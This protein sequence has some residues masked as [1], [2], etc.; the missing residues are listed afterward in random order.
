LGADPA[1]EEIAHIVHEA[2][3]A[4]DRFDAPIAAGLD[5]LIRGV[6]LTSDTD[7]ATLAVTDRLFDGLYEH[8]RRHLLSGRP[9]A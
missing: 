5:A 7:H 3:L 8:I 6:S 1:L 9:P 4:D 2:D